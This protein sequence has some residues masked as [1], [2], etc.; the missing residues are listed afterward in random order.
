MLPE[1]AF[2]IIEERI[3]QEKNIVQLGSG[4]L[5]HKWVIQRSRYILMDD[6][7]KSAESE[8][9]AHI[10]K[11]T[12]GSIEEF[13]ADGLNGRGESRRFLGIKRGA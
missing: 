8:F 11:L 12:N 3:Y 13:S 6:T 9:T 10:S 4:N 1:K 7:D 5:G 2:G